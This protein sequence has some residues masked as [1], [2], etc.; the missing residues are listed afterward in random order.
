[1]HFLCLSIEFHNVSFSR[2]EYY[3]LFIHLYILC[4][5]GDF[6][7]SQLRIKDSSASSLFGK[8]RELWF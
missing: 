2:H 3:L 1:M 7:K 4:T 6:P 8:Y 5:T